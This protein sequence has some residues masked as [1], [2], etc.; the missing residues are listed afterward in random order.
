M[1]KDKTTEWSEITLQNGQ[2]QN[3]LTTFHPR[4]QYIM[5]L[6]IFNTKWLIVK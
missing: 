5:Y 2:R 3:T 6:L 1:L 4:L